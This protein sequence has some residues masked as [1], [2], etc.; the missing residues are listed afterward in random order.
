MCDLHRNTPN[1]N[2][3]CFAP[4]PGIEFDAQFSAAITTEPCMLYAID[5]S[6]CEGAFM[7][8]PSTSQFV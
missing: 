1:H 5:I 3:D 4:N 6:L 7:V 8:E 2:D